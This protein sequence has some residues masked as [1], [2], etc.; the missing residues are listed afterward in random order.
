MPLASDD[1][2]WEFLNDKDSKTNDNLEN[3]SSSDSND[4]CPSVNAS[5]QPPSGEWY[6]VSD[7]R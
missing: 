7:S 1:P 6:L 3:I 4:D 2:R 5:V